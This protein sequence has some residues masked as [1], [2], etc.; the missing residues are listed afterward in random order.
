M[1]FKTKVG[2]LSAITR[3]IRS[4]IMLEDSKTSNFAGT[5]TQLLF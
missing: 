2:N 4:T 5:K 1:R 3:F